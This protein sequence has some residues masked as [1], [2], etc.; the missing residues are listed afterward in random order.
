M[1]PY[2]YI[3]NNP[4][5]GTDPS[6]Y[7][8]A[9]GGVYDINCKDKFE[10]YYAGLKAFVTTEKSNGSACKVGTCGGQAAMDTTAT[11]WVEDFDG[12]LTEEESRR[13]GKKSVKLIATGGTRVVLHLNDSS[14]SQ[15][16]VTRTGGRVI[17]FL[18]SKASKK[19]T[20]KLKDTLLSKLRTLDVADD[21]LSTY[22]DLVENLYVD[23]AALIAG[24][25]FVVDYDKFALGRSV[26]ALKKLA[27]AQGDD[28]LTD[29]AY[30]GERSMLARVLLGKGD[31]YTLAWFHHETTESSMLFPKHRYDLPDEY[32]NRQ[33]EAH[34]RTL[35]S[36]ENNQWDLYHPTVVSAYSDYF[37]PV[38]PRE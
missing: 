16:N 6:G 28:F 21:I 19:V 4:L 24:E 7:A 26:L 25:N 11:M 2:S 23:P 3:M 10:Q 9:C 18:T 17:D 12:L 13:L 15:G 30:A 1:N 8:A 31:K 14:S 38:Y 22:E 27:E 32:L 33:S 36:H 37:G 5:S 35:K 29:Q 34:L 20:D